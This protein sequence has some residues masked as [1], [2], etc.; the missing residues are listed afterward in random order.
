VK[1]IDAERAAEVFEHLATMSG[2]VESRGEVV[3]HVVDEPGGEIEEEL[4]LERLEDPFDA[5]AVIENAFQHEIPDLVS[6][7][8]L[9][10]TLSGVLRKVVEQSHR[11]AYSP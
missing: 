1:F 7:L 10:R 9:E 2:H 3:E 6:Y 5:H 11:V 8:A 4:T